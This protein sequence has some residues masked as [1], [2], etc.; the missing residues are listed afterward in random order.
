MATLP[1]REL[2]LELQDL[3]VGT[4]S[5]SDFLM[6]LAGVAAR[7]MSRSAL[8]AVECAVTLKRR[9]AAVTV[10][11]SSDWAVRLDRLEQRLGPGPCV[12]ALQTGK[13]VLLDDARIDPRWP[14][15]RQQLL[16]EGCLSV[17][18]VP[19]QLNE[20]AFATLNFFTF[21]ASV[22]S[23]EAL[24]DAAGFAGIAADAVRLA[25]KFA[26]LQGLAEDMEKAMKSRTAID[27]ACGII[28]A[29]NRCTQSE[30]MAILVKASSGRNQKLR[31]LAEE[32]VMQATGEKPRTHFDQGHQNRPANN[33]RTPGVEIRQE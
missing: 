18:G 15:Y 2:L 31:D 13:T 32:I 7:T 20:E 25:V 3:V 21:E 17:L 6:R 12:E 28:I 24:R 30:A 16:E 29:Q 26:N 10:G 11:G 9:R 8:S 14:D 19:M 22:F 5:V 27:V 23:D 1:E 4:E 33:A